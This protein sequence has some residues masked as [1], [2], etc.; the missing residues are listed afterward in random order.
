MLQTY[1]QNIT[2]PANAP[3][4]FNN[5]PLKKGCTTQ[6]TAP[7]TIALEKC[8]VYLVEFDAVA[9][10]TT[11]PGNIT[12]QLSV[13]GVPQPQALTSET[14]PSAT[15]FAAIGF[16]TLVQVSHNNSRC[17]CDVAT[18]IMLNNIGVEALF[19]QANVVVTKIC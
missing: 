6:K 19:Q 9:A 10:A 11:T 4:P 5:V 2:V 13:D 16:K 17:C 14:S 1:S 7:S 8:G 18:V 15:D 12:V 3:I